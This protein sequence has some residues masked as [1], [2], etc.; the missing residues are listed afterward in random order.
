MRSRRD[1]RAD[2]S[3]QAKAPQGPRRPKQSE[4]PVAQK[5]THQCDATSRRDDENEPDEAPGLEASQCSLNVF[6]L[7]IIQT[8]TGVLA[9]GER[10]HRLLSV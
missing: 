10:V 9:T 3:D 4:N 1:W 2:D 5:G 7:L 8:Q 6:V